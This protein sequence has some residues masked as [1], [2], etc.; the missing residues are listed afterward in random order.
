[1]FSRVSFVFSSSRATKY[2]EDL[3]HELRKAI[4]TA[5]TVET[6]M[7]ITT[8]FPRASPMLTSVPSVGS[9]EVIGACHVNTTLKMP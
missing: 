1:M 9:G 7:R 6:D 3:F 8:V 5:P 4:G 2:E